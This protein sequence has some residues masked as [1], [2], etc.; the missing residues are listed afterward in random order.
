M[1]NEILFLPRSTIEE[2]GIRAIDA[3]APLRQ[4][5]EDK[6]VDPQTEMPPKPGVHPRHDMNLHA[7]LAYLPT[8][9][10][11]GMK[12]LGG[13]PH[14][15]RL[16]GLPYF[17]GIYV[18]NDSNNGLPLAIIE[19]TWITET[20]TAVAS[21]MSIMAA[22]RDRIGSVAILGAGAQGS[23]HAQVFSELLSGL[24]E[25]RIYDLDHDRAASVA[26]TL[27]A[28]RACNSAEEALD[29][30]T[31]VVSATPQTTPPRRDQDG[32]GLA[33]GAAI[34][35]LD[36][37]S[38]WDLRLFDRVALYVVDDLEQYLFF[39]TERGSFAGYPDE[40]AELADVLASVVP[41]PDHGITFFEN[42]GLGIEDVAM[43]KVIY[44]RARAMGAGVE[45]Q[46]R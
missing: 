32:A 24:T 42:L 46:L 37:D 8:A 15:P 1:G 34:V 9:D 43:A 31:A 18:L 6:R 7:S 30:A 3:V 27:P 4:A 36:F 26:A 20:R 2:L 19:A 11:A 40:A 17:S 25:L 38:T 13:Y 5:F 22:R 44:D 14:N 12:W 28:A 35:A 16:Y 29:S 23:R 10:I 21:A 39:K 45:L 33:D 41:V